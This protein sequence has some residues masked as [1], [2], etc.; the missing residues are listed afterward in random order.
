MTEEDWALGDD[1][2]GQPRGWWMRRLVRA[3][4]RFFKLAREYEVLG[5]WLTTAGGAR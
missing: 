3:E 5:P 2:N 4:R 1:A